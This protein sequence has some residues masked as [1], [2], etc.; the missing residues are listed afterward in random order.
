MRVCGVSISNSSLNL[1]PFSGCHAEPFFR[2]REH[3]VTQGI[4]QVCDTV[5][6]AMGYFYNEYGKAH[7]IW[8]IT[9]VQ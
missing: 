2:D 4:P 5:S 3:P 6:I 7:F 8:K 1:T 9:E